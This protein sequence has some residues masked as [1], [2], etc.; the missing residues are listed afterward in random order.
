MAQLWKAFARMFGG[1]W[2]SQYGASD[3]GTWG[4]ALRFVD[5]N[6]FEEAIDR[7]IRDGSGFPPTLPEFVS[8]CS[9]CMG[10]PDASAAYL[11]ACHSRWT[12][13]TV[14]ETANRVGLFELS[15]RSEKEMLPR[16]K[17]VFGTVCAEWMADRTKFA[18]EPLPAIAVIEKAECPREVAMAAILEARKSLG[19]SK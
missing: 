6:S 8:I 1:R 13:D 15:H 3:N 11:D 17:E 14:Y 10:L 2:S 12:H 7:V 18:R 16:F 5:N 4:M 19:L 9:K